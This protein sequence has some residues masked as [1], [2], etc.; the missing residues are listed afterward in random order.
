MLVNDIAAYP[1]FLDGCVGADILAQD[2]DSITARLQLKKGGISQSFATRNQ[3]QR[4]H[5]IQLQLVE[6]PFDQWQGEWRFA[7]L[8]SDACKV[9]LDLS[10]SLQHALTQKATEKLLE[11]VASNLVNAI[12]QRANKL[13]G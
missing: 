12:C 2:E 5:R 3:L 8:A 1:E 7:A 9:S 6:G 13:Y 4:P 10:F 11:G